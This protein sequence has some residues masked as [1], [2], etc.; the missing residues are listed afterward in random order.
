MDQTGKGLHR[1]LAVFQ[2]IGFGA[3]IALGFG[4]GGPPGEIGDV[5]VAG[6][7]DQLKGHARLGE[8]IKK[9]CHHGGNG[10]PLHRALRGHD[11]RIIPVHGD[12]GFHFA[13]LKSGQARVGEFQSSVGVL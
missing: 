4:C 7:R 1:D 2:H 11:H 10:S 12:A 9:R 3:E 5:A 13:T 8:F 6:A